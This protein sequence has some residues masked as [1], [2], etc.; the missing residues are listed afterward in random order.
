MKQTT[1]FLISL[2]EI[3]LMKEIC[4]RNIKHANENMSMKSC[5]H[6]FEREI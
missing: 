5:W 2:K 3:V 1:V 6:F 4:A